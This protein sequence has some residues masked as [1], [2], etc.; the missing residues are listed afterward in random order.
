[1]LA[2]QR[3]VGATSPPF[4]F[5]RIEVREGKPLRG[6]DWRL[7]GA[8]GVLLSVLAGCSPSG[9]APA[10]YGAMNASLYE[11]PAVTVQQGKAFFTWYDAERQLMLGDGA[12]VTRISEASA[13][14]SLLSHN[15][16][17]A[18]E[19]ALYV[20]WRPKIAAGGGD[21]VGDKSL[22]FRASYDGGRTFSPPAALNNKGAAAMEPVFASN[23]TGALYAAWNDERDGKFDIYL[24]VSRDGG[25]TWLAEEMRLDTD[26]PGSVQS[27]D[28]ALQ[29]EGDRAWAIWVDGRKLLLRSSP[30]QGRTW[31]EP[32][33]LAQGGMIYA[34]RFLRLRERLL[35][36]WCDQG[37]ERFQYRAKGLA[38][39][40]GG[41]T[42]HPLSDPGVRS[43]M[44]F[45]IEAATDGGSR[46][47]LAMASRGPQQRKGV[48]NIY[49]T[50]SADGGNAWSEPVRLQTNTPYHTFAILPRL[51]A[52][53]EGGVAVVWVDYRNIRANVYANVSRNGGKDWLAEERLLST[54][55][56]NANL[57]ALAADGNGGFHAVWLEYADAA[58]KKGAVVLKKVPA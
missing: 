34:P 56:S 45:E 54:L 20:L 47:Y 41:H 28:M 37:P 25:R 58:M 35:I 16:L 36:L 4:F 3:G 33:V 10:G 11:G 43:W 23:G 55:S 44:Q 12:T 15:L 48:D 13:L 9:P 1:M 21:K 18:D 5:D 26:A 49:F 40:D 14:P 8:G 27:G 51:A 57:P 39:D 42:W 38:S 7:L 50:A 2:E 53:K 30:D 19:R 32:R 46:L 52:D 22:L 24:N 31:E 6:L 29:A 17:R